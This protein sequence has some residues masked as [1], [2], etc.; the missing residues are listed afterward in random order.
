MDNRKAIFFANYLYQ[1]VL[2]HDEYHGVNSI[3]SPEMLH[4]IQA[5]GD[6]YLNLK[7]LR[8]VTEEEI[9][10]VMQIC[11]LKSELEDYKDF[12]EMIRSQRFYVEY[13]FKCRPLYFREVTEAMDYLRSK[14]YAI[15]WM[16]IEVEELVSMG[17]IKLLS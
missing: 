12:Y 13:L 9:I 6:Y 5:D 1:N 14:G 17:W 10:E 3:N 11:G 8:M 15:S 2:C 4:K 16:G 7:P